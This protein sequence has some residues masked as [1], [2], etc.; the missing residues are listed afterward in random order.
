MKGGGEGL[1]GERARDY[2]NFIHPKMG[3]AK[4]T[5]LAP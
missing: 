1:N 4:E 2:E 3:Y 5:I